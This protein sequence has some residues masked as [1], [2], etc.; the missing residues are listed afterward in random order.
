MIPAWRL[1][2]EEHRTLDDASNVFMALEVTP[3]YKAWWVR[4]HPDDRKMDK[5]DE[6]DSEGSSKENPYQVNKPIHNI[7]M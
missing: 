2:W 6:V 5:D 7:P 4:V 1:S 3:G